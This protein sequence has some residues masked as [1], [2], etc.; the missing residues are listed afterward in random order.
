MILPTHLSSVRSP[1]SVLEHY[2]PLLNEKCVEVFYEDVYLHVKYFNP[3]TITH[4]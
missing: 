2:H 1:L 4:C 3:F